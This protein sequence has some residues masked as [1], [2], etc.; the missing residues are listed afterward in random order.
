M[1]NLIQILALAT[2]VLGSTCL[3]VNAQTT[4]AAGLRAQVEKASP[5]IKEAACYGWGRHCPPGYG[6]GC[7]Y[8]RCWCHP[9]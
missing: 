4:G 5:M 8:G 9:C 2:L 3:S 1:K 6:W 7:A